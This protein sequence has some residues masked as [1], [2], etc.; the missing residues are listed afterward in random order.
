MKARAATLLLCAEHPE[1]KKLFSEL[2]TRASSGGE[3]RA[4]TRKPKQP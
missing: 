3:R 2:P 1:S 4:E